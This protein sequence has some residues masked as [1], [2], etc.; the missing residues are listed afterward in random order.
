MSEISQARAS[1]V[2]ALAQ[3]L[4]RTRE[5]L[6]REAE[7]DYDEIHSVKSVLYA[8]IEWLGIKTDRLASVQRML[9]EL[10]AIVTAKAD[11]RIY[12]RDVGMQILEEITKRYGRE[13]LE[14]E[15]LPK[16][17]VD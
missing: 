11:L 4:E 5:L 16:A 14:E 10:F 3:A 17:K 8:A 6:A 2:R 15:M 13:L 7:I 1:Y 9:R 12:E